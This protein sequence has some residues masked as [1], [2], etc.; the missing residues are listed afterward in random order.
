MLPPVFD[1]PPLELPPVLATVVPPLPT[2]VLPPVV[3]PLPPVPV[4]PP[5]VAPIEP[6]VVTPTE[7]PLPRAGL[8]GL[9][10]L[11]DKAATKLVAA[12]AKNEP[13]T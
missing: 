5:V 12:K 6:P 2:V 3:L 8:L 7:P 11:A 13:E 1:T 9:L 4:T 10:Q